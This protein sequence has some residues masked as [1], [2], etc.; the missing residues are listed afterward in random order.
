MGIKSAGIIS[1]GDC[2]TTSL[3]DFEN[4]Y[5]WRCTAGNDIYDPCFATPGASDVQHVACPTTRFSGV[6]LLNLSSHL[7]E[8]STPRTSGGT[9]VW[10]I[11]LSNGQGCSRF[12]GA[13][14]PMVN[15]VT[16]D[17]VCTGGGAGEPDRS[18]HPWEDQYAARWYPLNRT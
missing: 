6:Y 12:D 7:A 3:V 5:A 11:V 16:L 15:G 9:Y 2:W 13:G 17:Y 1:G 4:A 8:S 10:Y 14:P 18:A